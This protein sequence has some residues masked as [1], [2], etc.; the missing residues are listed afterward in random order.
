MTDDD[1]LLAVIEGWPTLNAARRKM[2]LK[3]VQP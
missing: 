2:I 3:L 1:I